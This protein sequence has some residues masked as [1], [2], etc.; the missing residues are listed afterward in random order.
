MLGKQLRTFRPNL[1]PNG[2]AV[3]V[4]SLGAGLLWWVSQR[5]GGAP[6]SVLGF[7]VL[8]SALALVM[9]IAF[10][11]ETTLRVRAHEHG[12]AW[13][14]AGRS[15]E[16]T[17]AEIKRIHEMTSSVLIF[18]KAGG[19]PLTLPTTVIDRPALLAHLSLVAPVLPK[20]TVVMR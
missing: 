1:L 14:R 18:T 10:Q 8:A 19:K 13:S 16:V 9:M 11:R 7:A 15:Y 3:A 12:I 6:P 17:F 5:V 2:L 4:L 20:A